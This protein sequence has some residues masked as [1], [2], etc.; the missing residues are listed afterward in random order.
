MSFEAIPIDARG[1]LRFRFRGEDIALR[2]FSPR[3]TVLDW[4]REE[5][6]AKGT[7]EGCAEV[8]CGAC[9]VVLARL[10]GGR[11]AYEPFNA[12]IL[13]L[14]QLDGA[15]LITIEDLAA[16]RELHPLQQAMVDAHASQCGFCTPGIVM[17][18]FA[19]Y[20][21][22]QPM[23]YAG[24]C[25]QLAGNLC[26]CTG[27]RPIIAAA[28]ETCNGAPADH[29]A[30]TSQERAAALAALDDQRDVFVSGEGA[31][32][33]APASL[34]S[35]AALYARFPDTTLVGG[36]TDVGLWITKQ[37]RDL[38]R[39]IWLGRVAGLD[40]VG[41]SADGALSLGATL[42]LE[43]AA[44][45][46]G[47]IHP[48]LSE[49]LRRFGSKQVRASGT[50]GGNIA[51]GSPIGDLAPALIALGGRVVLR[52]GDNT[53][54]IPLEDFFIAYGKQDRE[55]GEFVVAVEAPRL[56]PH[57]HYRALKVSKR[58]DEDISAVM[59]A[60]RVNLDGRRIV[61]ARVACGGMA[62]T[63]KRA[64]KAERALVGASL[65]E[66]ATW[67]FAREA[68]GEDFT[69]LTDLRATAAYR[70]AVAANLLEKALVEISGGSA[71]TRIGM[72]HAAE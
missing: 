46:L 67:R 36:A 65:D 72:L 31:F 18:L 35:L 50:V 61:G 39:V 22:G 51:N 53:R 10:R 56:A 30:A 25:D 47:A 54:A 27:Y 49:L 24:L 13:L 48:D 11:L 45:L 71:P 28:M 23:T 37:L 19:G 44:P 34:E 43:D 21:S 52:K 1:A 41:E 38:K 4:L 66:P 3:A 16:G 63:P 8:D 40:G 2:Q 69:P 26:R 9:T 7:K 42:K 5:M 55:P 12:C 6:G 57:Q 20:H 14:G 68:I 32:F 59:L 29:F 64:V 58:L 15:E 62:A 70:K 33:A 17:S 60:V